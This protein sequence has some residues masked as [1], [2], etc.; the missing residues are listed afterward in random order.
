MSSQEL[1][2]PVLGTVD[3]PSKTHVVYRKKQLG[4]KCTQS[5]GSFTSAPEEATAVASAECNLKL[6][7]ER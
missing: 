5:P 6:R 4:N 7:W 1:S 3:T 2:V